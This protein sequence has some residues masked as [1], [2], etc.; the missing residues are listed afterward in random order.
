MKWCTTCVYPES[1]AVK[2]SFDEEGVCSGCRVNAEKESIDWEEREKKLKELVAPYKRTDGGYDML[3][4]VSGGKDSYYQTY[5]ATHVL[6]LKPLLVTYHGNNYL[7]VGEKNLFRMRHIFDV[8]HIIA[9]PSV[10]VLKKL[11]RLTFKLM[12]D[13][14][15][16]AH[17]GIFSFP[18]QMA[19]KFNIPLLM[20]GEH[21]RLDRGGQYSLY[22]FVEMSARDFREHHQR[23]YKW[24]DLTDEGLKKLNKQDIGEGLTAHDF[25]FFEYPTIEELDDI[26]IRGIFLGN[27]VY[28]DPNKQTEFVMKEFGWEASPEPFERT[29]RTISN[30]DDMHETGIKD[31]LKYVKFGYGRCTDHV[32]KDIRLGYMTREEGIEMVKKCDHVRSK[33]FQRWF[34]YAGMSEEQFDQICDTFRDPKIWWKDENGEWVK[35]NIWDD[36]VTLEEKRAQQREYLA[37]HGPETSA[38]S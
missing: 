13:M 23:G 33:D 20:W 31:Y 38:T 34:D 11:N 37:A 18:V 21:G 28:W 36:E 17:S 35:E 6:G 4:P 25:T 10:G 1:S 2:L 32:S 29:F 7:P 9:G 3:I 14:S 22:D 30:L 26:G 15:W 12:G 27:Y 5:Y 19:A 24:Q 16:H 8:D